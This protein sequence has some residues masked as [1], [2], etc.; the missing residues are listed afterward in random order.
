MFLCRATNIT[1]AV[2]SYKRELY[3]ERDSDGR[4]HV[5]QK[6]PYWPN[7]PRYV[8]SLTHNWNMRG[9]TVD[10]GIEPILAKIKAMDL[11]ADGG[12]ERFREMLEQNE[13]FDASREREMKNTIESFVRD[14]R[15]QF[16]RATNDVNTGSMAKL[17]KRRLKDA[18]N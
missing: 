5:Y 8:L 1:K 3:C 10:W 15:P 4:Y 14:M 11:C 18:F 13:K 7:P 17:D 9:K 12:H 16:A 6:A 2:R